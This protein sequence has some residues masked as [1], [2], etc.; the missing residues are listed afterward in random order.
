[1]INPNLI[2]DLFRTE[3][4]KIVGVLCK[5]FGISNIELAEDIVSE[6]FLVATETWSLHGVPEN[7]KAWVCNSQE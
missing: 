2:S 5:S 6:T 4:G 7:P 1:M 3:F